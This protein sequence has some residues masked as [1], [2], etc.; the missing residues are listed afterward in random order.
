MY[1]LDVNNAFLHGELDEE[2]YMQMPQ[3]IPNPSNKVCRLKKSLYVLKQAGRQWFS[4]LKYTILSLGYTQSK[5]DYSLFLNKTSTLITV[6]AVYV[7]DI[8]IIGSDYQEI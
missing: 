3:G 6:L 2:V 8:L 1:Q 5:N 4:K 7:D